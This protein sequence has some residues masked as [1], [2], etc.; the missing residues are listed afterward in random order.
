L[1]TTSELVAKT[2]VLKRI[3]QNSEWPEFHWTVDRQKVS[4]IWHRK[5]QFWNLI[6]HLGLTLQIICKC[7]ITRVLQ[8]SKVYSK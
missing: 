1:K 5:S 8:K 6:R 3:F 2:M 4:F 7:G